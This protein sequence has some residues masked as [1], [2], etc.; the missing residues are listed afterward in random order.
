M[1]KV[2]IGIRVSKSYNV[3]TGDRPEGTSMSITSGVNRRE[4]SSAMAWKP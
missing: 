1:E 2:R 3:A 4:A